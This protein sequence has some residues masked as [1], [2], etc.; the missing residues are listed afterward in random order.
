MTALPRSP[1]CGPRLSHTTSSHRL[2]VGVA[3]SPSDRTPTGTTSALIPIAEMTRRTGMAEGAGVGRTALLP[4]GIART[5]GV[6][7]FPWLVCFIPGSILET[8]EL[9]HAQFSCPRREEVVIDKDLQRQVARLGA[10]GDYRV[11][12]TG[13]DG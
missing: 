2:R 6:A 12:H 1:G 10:N 9:L 13:T 4:V 7:V 8:A 11:S 5:P 3:R